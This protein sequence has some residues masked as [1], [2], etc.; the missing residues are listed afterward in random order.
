MVEWWQIVV[1]LPF[2]LLGIVWIV[3][4]FIKAWHTKVTADNTSVIVTILLGIVILAPGLY[5]AS[6]FGWF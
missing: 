4:G 6:M 1:I 3:S 2:V 5:F